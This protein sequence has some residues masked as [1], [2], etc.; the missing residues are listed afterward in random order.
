MS[1]LSSHAFT[2][3]MYQM[4]HTKGDDP[5]AGAAFWLATGIVDNY[6]IITARRC[7][8]PDGSQPVEYS[9]MRCG[10]CGKAIDPRDLS[11]GERVPAE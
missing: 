7:V 6:E 3:P 11:K 1:L 5:C 9:R 4:R 10:S 2:E 8:M